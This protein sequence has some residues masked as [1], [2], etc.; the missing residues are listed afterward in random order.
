MFRGACR[1]FLCLW[2]L[3]LRN[4]EVY[5]RIIMR[6]EFSRFRWIACIVTLLLCIVGSSRLGMGTESVSSSASR[7]TLVAEETLESV[8]LSS[9]KNDIF[10]HLRETNRWGLSSAA[11]HL[12]VPIGRT[13][14]F[15]NTAHRIVRMAMACACLCG[16]I[17]TEQQNHTQCYTIASIRF[18][19]GYFIYHRCQ[20]RC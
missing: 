11:L 17:A 3:F 15:G 1:T 7:C 6:V 8:V 14:S 9:P 2:K 18:H 20:M 5:L 4:K 16:H 13:F 19:I 10:T 12:R